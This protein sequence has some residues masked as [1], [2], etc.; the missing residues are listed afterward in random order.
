MRARLGKLGAAVAALAA[1]AFSGSALASAA[2]GSHAIAAT[3]ARPHLARA[4][5]AA[6]TQHLRATVRKSGEDPGASEQQGESGSVGE[7]D[8]DAAA[9]AAACQKAGIDPNADNVQYDDQAGTCTLDTG[10]GANS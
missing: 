4:H 6:R 1:L 7:S 3:A 5:T 9:Q 8:N 10:G 2:G